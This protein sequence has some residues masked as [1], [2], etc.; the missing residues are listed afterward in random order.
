MGIFGARYALLAK[1]RDCRLFPLVTGVYLNL[2][3]AL[4]LREPHVLRIGTI[5]ADEPSDYVRI[6]EDSDLQWKIVAPRRVNS[7]VKRLFIQ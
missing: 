2:R 3:V 7:V 1:H 6:V 4:A 5:S